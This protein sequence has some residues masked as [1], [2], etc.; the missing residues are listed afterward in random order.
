MIHYKKFIAFLILVL[1]SSC[2][3]LYTIKID[4]DWIASVKIEG[5][6]GNINRYYNSSI[7][8]NLDTS[9]LNSNSTVSFTVASVD[10]LGLYLPDLEC[11]C[12][13]FNVQNNNQLV[14]ITDS[15]DTICNNNQP[16]VKDFAIFLSFNKEITKVT[17]NNKKYHKHKRN[18][19][20]L[21][22]SKNKKTKKTRKYIIYF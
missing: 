16:V 4:N 15:G 9:L 1:F 12:V 18:S 6:N 14:I 21:N 13:V 22:F 2:V 3:T 8:S 10:S 7:I 19:V 20:S 11:E 5:F 17:L